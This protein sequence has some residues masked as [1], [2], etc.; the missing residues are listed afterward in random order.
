MDESL[1]RSLSLHIDGR[2]GS[3]PRLL[4]YDV[5]IV[6]IEYIHLLELLDQVLHSQ[7]LAPL[8]QEIIQLLVEPRLS[9]FWHLKLFIYP[10]FELLLIVLF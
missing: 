8:K 3:G 6:V 1:R 5:S 2:E 9:V 7:A 10:L 4:L